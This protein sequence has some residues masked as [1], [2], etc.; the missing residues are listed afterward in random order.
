VRPTRKIASRAIDTD[1][2]DTYALA[3]RATLKM[4]MGDY[5]GARSDLER[6]FSISSTNLRV[7]SGHVAVDILEHKLDAALEHARALPIAAERDLVNAVVLCA[8]G[9]RQAGLTAISAGYSK[10][11]VNFAGADG[12]YALCGEHDKTLSILEA[13]T[14]RIYDGMESLKYDPFLVPLRNEPRFHALLKKLNLPT[15]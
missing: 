4:A 12:A 7:I 1:P 15:D 6:A 2:L 13:E 8:R 3:W 5:T 10:T 9:E 11:E 14:G